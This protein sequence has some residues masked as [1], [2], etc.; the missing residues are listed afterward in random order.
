MLERG[1]TEEGRKE[2]DASGEWVGEA[3]VALYTRR[4]AA[5]GKLLV[6]GSRPLGG[7]SCGS[8]R[9]GGPLDR[10]ARLLGRFCPFPRSS[11]SVRGGHSGN[12][13]WGLCVNTAGARRFLRGEVARGVR[14]LARLT[15]WPTSASCTAAN[16]FFCRSSSS[17]VLCG[18]ASHYVVYYSYVCA[19]ESINTSMPPFEITCCFTLIEERLLS[20][21]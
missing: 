14:R 6:A 9:D 16:F 15:A 5:Q 2:M 1:G 19:L 18:I 12:F 21:L 13:E 20:H 4:P 3:G 17:V 7:R 11:H 8:D 10:R